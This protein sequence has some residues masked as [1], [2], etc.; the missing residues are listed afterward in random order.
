MKSESS[1]MRRTY[2][3]EGP[4]YTERHVTLIRV[5]HGLSQKVAAEPEDIKKS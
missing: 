1:K 4:G 3:E 5:A 2:V